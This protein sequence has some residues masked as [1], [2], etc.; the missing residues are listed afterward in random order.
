M[1]M[2]AEQFA[3]ATLEAILED[4]AVIRATESGTPYETYRAVAEE[5]RAVIYQV[6]E[7]AAHEEHQ[8]VATADYLHGL[9]EREPLRSNPTWEPQR[10]VLGLFLMGLTSALARL[11]AIT[12]EERAALLPAYY[13]EAGEAVRS[14]DYDEPDPDADPANDQE[15]DVPPDPVAASPTDADEFSLL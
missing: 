7:M 13:R 5:L 6:A 2:P 10:V 8:L 15:E 12:A 14:I 11:E 1:T 9:L 3:A 4:R